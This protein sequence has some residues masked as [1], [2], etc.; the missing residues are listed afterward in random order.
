M[1]AT[2]GYGQFDPKTMI[3]RDED[4][5]AFLYRDQQYGMGQ[6]AQPY[7]SD[8]YLNN[9]WRLFH[10]TFP[11]VH[12]STF[13][14]M[15]SSPMLRAAMVA[16]DGQYSNDAETKRIARVLHDRCIKMLEKVG[17]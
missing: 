14:S 8:Q 5:A 15:S 2:A 4:E 11:V 7:P 16:I 3:Q 17:S 10:P 9:Y 13:E 6:L 12:R 1:E